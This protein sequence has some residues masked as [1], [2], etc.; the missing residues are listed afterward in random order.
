M[1]LFFNKI[2]RNACIAVAAIT[3]L[4]G[5]SAVALNGGLEKSIKY[6]SL[7]DQLIAEKGFI[8][9]VNQPHIVGKDHGI[10]GN[11]ISELTGG[12]RERDFSKTL[13]AYKR[14]FLNCKAIGYD[15]VKIWLFENMDGIRV[16]KSGDIL[17]FDDSFMNNFKSIMDLAQQIGMPLDITLTPH[18][19]T[20][21]KSEYGYGSD[22]LMLY[23]T[24][25]QFVVNPEYREHYIDRIIKPLCQEINT[26]Y[27]DTLL[28]VT[29]YCEPEGDSYAEGDEVSDNYLYGTSWDILKDYMNDVAECLHKNLPHIPVTATSGWN[30]YKTYRYND[31][32]LDVV[33]VDVYNNTA[34]LPSPETSM[35][36]KPMWL[37]EFGPDNSAGYNHD[38][39][40]QVSY[41]MAFYNN[42]KSAGY[43]GAFFWGYSL[44][45]PMS[46][47]YSNST[48]SSL[49]PAAAALHYTIVDRE[50]SINGVTTDDIA[51][52]PALLYSDDSLTLQWIASR[53]ADSYTIEVSD[54]GGES[55]RK[56]GTVEDASAATNNSNICHFDISGLNL[57]KNA[58]FRVSVI[59]NTGLSATSDPLT[60]AVPKI[61]CS[62][63]ENIITNGGFELGTSGWIYSD[64]TCVNIIDKT[65]VGTT[66]RGNKCILLA[67][68]GNQA[69]HQ[70]HNIHQSVH[71]KANTTYRVTFYSKHLWDKSTNNFKITSGNDETNYI[72]TKMATGNDFTLNTYTFTVGSKDDTATVY[73]VNNYENIYVDSVYLFEEKQ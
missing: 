12:T 40:F 69:G 57:G 53:D 44:T 62:D 28:S 48:Y 10:G 67:G 19:E 13:D 17:G 23:N 36:N 2:K 49:R 7:Y 46:M 29:V 26:N 70:W 24:L 59:T 18:Q 50:N 31:I 14:V 60:F 45:A 63:S 72:N 55:W 61:I 35:V 38:D 25:T 8:Y 6:D 32:D 1:K 22:S 20:L 58:S 42:A 30:P 56:A 3:A 43:T 16:S 27:R 33:G 64:D 52:K 47:T 5:I 15:A 9:G 11:T 54:N 41:M 34:E 73:F 37:T 66:H 51:D 39:G 71:L 4:A 68:E 21:L 65:D